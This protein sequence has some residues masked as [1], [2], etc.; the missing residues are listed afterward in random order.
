MRA[1]ITSTERRMN[2]NS[3]TRSLLKAA[4]LTVLI[5]T[6]SLSQTRFEI[7]KIIFSGNKS[8]SSK[9]LHQIIISKET[10]PKLWKLLAR[11]NPKLGAKPSYLNKT[12]IGSDIIALKNFYQNNGF[13]D[14]KIDTNIT[15]NQNKK[16]AT[17]KFI[18][19][20]NK[21]YKIKKIKLNIKDE[22]PRNI[23]NK[24]TKTVFIQ[25]GKIF[26]T[27]D[28]E[29]EIARILDLLYN[30][31]YPEAYIDKSQT[32]ILINKRNKTVSIKIP[33]T[34]DGRFKI[35]K[36]EISLEDSSKLIIPKDII[37]REI[38]FKKGQYYSRNAKLKSEVNLIQ[39]GLFDYAKITLV[40]E[41]QPKDTIP[42]KAKI[43][44]VLYPKNK[45]DIQPALYLTDERNAFNVGIAFNYLNRN[46]LGGGRFLNAD[47]RAQVQ[48]LNFKNLPDPEDTTSAGTIEANLKLTQPY[49]FGKKTPVEWTLS[50]I[51]DKQREYV[52][53]L[54][55]S[56][57]R[58]NY[59]ISKMLVG[60]F[61]WDIELANPLKFKP[62]ISEILKKLYPRQFNSI[63]T[64]SVQFDKT[65]DIFYPTSGVSYFISFEEAGLL[66]YFTKGLITL[67][68][69][70]YYKFTY[71]G[72][73]FWGLNNSVFA[74]KLKLGYAKEYRIKKGLKI[75][76]VPIHRRFFAGGSASV[77]GW[78]V[79]E[80]GNVP[81]PGLGG[82]ILIE[83]NI[84]A[85]FIISEKLRL[86]LVLFTDVGNLWNEIKSIKFKNFAIATGF[87]FRYLT[88]FG[89]FRLDFGFKL[90]D[91]K[92]KKRWLFEKDLKIVL[93]QMVFHIGVGQTF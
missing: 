27:K 73:W 79:R 24:I 55:R 5:I 35:D 1:M 85:R 42:G 39:T 63:L 92:Q 65:N 44:V 81:N 6:I 16:T 58:F 3:K 9:Q 62:S 13:F 7:E 18:I 89:G 15:Y 41:T 64:I 75:L 54:L 86:G 82:N 61:D 50:A 74:F 30:N 51:F 87:G 49:L 36:I 71:L 83:S 21:P 60:Y 8:F 66:P 20:E 28:L 57:L 52:L 93:K 56:K 69:S 46:F 59:R 40:P 53:A 31:G 48:R 12:I 84:E 76:P 22:L 26:R 38:A 29:S 91:P 70:Q 23:K 72:R 47:I 4:G 10:P 17:I 90:Y 32:E 43:K 80:L 19:Q 14:V 25:T 33:I 34:P 77:R 37:M 11:I 2:I 45:H 78:R 68:F 88:F 67:P